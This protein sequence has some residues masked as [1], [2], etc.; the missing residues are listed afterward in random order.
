[1]TG[2]SIRMKKRTAH[3]FRITVFLLFIISGIIQSPIIADPGVRDTLRIGSIEMKEN[4]TAAVPVYFYN[5]EELSAVLVV[6]KFDPED[7]IPDTFTLAGGRL[8][9]M[10]DDT[11]VY[12]DSANFV[13]LG[14][15]DLDGI[16]TGSGLLCS[17]YFKAGPHSGGEAHMVDSASWPIPPPGRL[18]CSFSD[19]N[20]S[21]ILPEFVPGYITVTESYMCGDADANKMLNL[22]D[23][24]YL[25]SFT[26][27]DP[28]GPAPVPLESGNVN[29]DDIINLSDILYLIAY[30]YIDPPGPEPICPD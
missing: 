10:P 5:D 24:L 14:I 9:Y 7:L 27:L 8:N 23:I 21:T 30:I 4:R 15:F 3:K 28:P 22:S 13:E 29:G 17:L 19:M 1:M 18:E 2:E 12:R 16:S 26:Y 6:L 25:I 20:F 11:A